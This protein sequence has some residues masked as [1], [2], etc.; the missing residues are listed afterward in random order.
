VG[1]ASATPTA[2][3][4]LRMTGDRTLEILTESRALLT[5]D[6]FVYVSDEH[7]DG[8]IDKD[9]VYP[10][11]ERSAE[12]GR[13]L[14]TA[15]EELGPEVVCGPATGGLIVAQWTAHALGAL[16]AFGEHPRG[17][18]EG[19]AR[20]FE[21]KRHFERVVAGRRV[22][23]VDDV[24]NTGYSLRGTIAAVRAAGGEVVGVGAVVNRGVA[25]A[26]TLGASA[27]VFLLEHPLASWPAA[28]CPLCRQGVPVNVDYAH[29]RE[30]VVR[31]PGGQASG[32][33]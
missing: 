25:T 2:L 6:H 24:V 18:H 33:P 9:A 4:V 16:A 30:F 11:T 29:G 5:D 10:H 23:V 32:Y 1:A 28:E 14:A 12:L 7:G 8:W 3:Y 15:T 26:G 20:P 17:F 27:F 22:L 31:S 21:L 19:D 13:L